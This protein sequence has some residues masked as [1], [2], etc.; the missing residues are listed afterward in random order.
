MNFNIRTD[1]ALENREIYQAA[2]KKEHE[3]PGIEA[4]FDDSDCD[5][6]ISTVKVLSK[7]GS[8]ALSKPIGEYITIES[9]YMNDEVEK[10]D[11]KIIKTLA[12]NIKKLANLKET[13]SVLVVGLRKFRCYSRRVRP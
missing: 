5:V 4:F 3:I 10:I 11:K 1:L 8:E 13:D 6:H 2:S 7:I 9:P 12:K